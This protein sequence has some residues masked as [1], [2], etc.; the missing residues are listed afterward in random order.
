MDLIRFAKP[1]VGKLDN[2]TLQ[3]VSK[4]NLS[5]FLAWVH[6]DLNAADLSAVRNEYDQRMRLIACPAP[7]EIIANDQRVAGA[8]LSCL[9][10]NLAMLGAVRADSERQS[11]GS[12]AIE[13]L[14]GQLR[15]T[16]PSCQIQATV[17]QPDPQSGHMIASAGFR[18][19]TTVE[20]WWIDPNLIDNPVLVGRASSKG[21]LS[22]IQRN[23]VRSFSSKSS[24]RESNKLIWR[25][26][27]ELSRRSFLRLFQET[28]E[29]TLD[30]PELSQ[31][32]STDQSIDSFLLGRKL[33]Q[34]RLWQV[35]WLNRRPVGCLLLSQHGQGLV[36]LVY[37]GIA[38]SQR[39]Q[40]LGA[41]MIQRAKEIASALGASTLVLAVDMRNS[42]A[43]RIYQQ[44][45]F[46]LHR[47][48]QVY[49]L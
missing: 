16:M 43:L 26:A 9:P 13:T 34:C 27:L 6:G 3:P 21:N 48:L 18:L 29:D 36:E 42:P 25:P 8:Y 38:A 19:L 15:E 24:V 23:E 44:A 28:L 5:S 20:Q 37:M 1:T 14:V 32:R 47:R 7:L 41:Q 11:L 4:G 31:L 22:L 35:A 45:G 33:R 46:Q 39:G 17:N 2:I 49:W 30:C 40:G 10:G 12:L